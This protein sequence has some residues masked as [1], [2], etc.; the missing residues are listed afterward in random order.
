MTTPTYLEN[1]GLLTDIY[2]YWPSFHDA[3]VHSISMDRDQILFDDVSDVRIGMVV[4][5]FEMT[6]EVKDNGCFGLIKHHLIQFEFSNVGD[7]TL[8]G[9]NHQNAIYGLLFEAQPEDAAGNTFFKVVLEAAHG[10]E[11]SFVPQTGKI[12][13]V[14]PCDENGKIGPPL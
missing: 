5:Y 3:E 2:G 1:H 6:R 10:V 9:F 13:A 12:V 11:G 8:S 7:I 14:T 4:H